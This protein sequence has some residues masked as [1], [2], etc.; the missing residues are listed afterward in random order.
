MGVLYLKTYVLLALQQH[1]HTLVTEA[2]LLAIF[3]QG[4][5]PKVGENLLVLVYVLWVGILLVAII[6]HQRSKYI[7]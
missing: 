3:L 5:A 2:R 6:I 1:I 4:T 7:A